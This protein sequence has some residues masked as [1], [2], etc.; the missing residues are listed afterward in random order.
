MGNPR[1][2]EIAAEY[3]LESKL[4]LR[5][6]MDMGVFVKGPSSS[7]APPVARRVRARLR[8]GGAVSRHPAVVLSPN[9]AAA[10]ANL[11]QK[12]PR[13][14]PELVDVI[15]ARPIK[16]SV[17][18]RLLVA[19]AQARRYY[20]VADDS[21]DAVDRAARSWN[22]LFVHDLPAPTG[23]AVVDRGKGRLRIVVWMT[24]PDGEIRTGALTLQTAPHPASPPQ[25]RLEVGSMEVVH[26][27]PAKGAP[28]AS[29]E[30]RELIGVVSSIPPRA[31]A[32]ASVARDPA[33]QEPTGEPPRPSSA[34]HLVYATKNVTNEP[35]VPSEHV[36][37][38]DSRWTVQ[39]H[40]REQWYSSLQTHKRVWIAQHAAGRADAPLLERD[41]VYIIRPS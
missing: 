34:V 29:P 33:R 16:T 4:V 37:H 15:T 36:T 25:Q 24:Q 10:A 20:Y 19:A 11:I 35:R 32:G 41:V 9:D 3:G 40:W 31:P 39:G 28:Y 2:H 38:R 7:I 14:I 17:A 30:L 21:V 6:L 23:V 8:E 12:L 18:G 22:R 26:V 1:V 13:S 27:D 5:Q